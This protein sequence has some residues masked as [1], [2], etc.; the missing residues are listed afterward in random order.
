[1]ITTMKLKIL[2]ATGWRNNRKCAKKL[3][4]SGMIIAAFVCSSCEAFLD[5]RCGDDYVLVHDHCV[6]E[7]TGSPEDV[8]I[9]DSGVGYGGEG[10]V[11][12]PTGMGN[13]CLEQVDCEGFEADF[14][15]KD[16]A[17][18]E[19]N[20]TFQDC[21]IGPDEDCPSQWKCC[22][23]PAGIPFPSFCIPEIAW[24]ATNATYGCE[25]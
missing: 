23:L 1:M 22:K 25:G 20:C 16:P 11:E 15:A 13:H 17:S 14:C 12:L 10:G 4:L 8:P 18:E 24:D 21:Q 2:V 3:L 5:D 6:P 7:T 9:P 19:G